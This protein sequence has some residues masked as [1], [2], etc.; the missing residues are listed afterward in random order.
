[1]FSREII[2]MKEKKKIIIYPTV[3]YVL[4]KGNDNGKWC[5][6]QYQLFTTYFHLY[7]RFTI[8]EFVF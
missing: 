6:W 4:R 8:I 5:I 3:V 7:I 1:M 2:M